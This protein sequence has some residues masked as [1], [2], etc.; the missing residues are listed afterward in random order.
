MDDRQAD[1]ETGGGSAYDDEHAEQTAEL[2]AQSDRLQHVHRMRHSDQ[3]DY[4]E[5]MDQQDYPS[6]QDADV[7]SYHQNQHQ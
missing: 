3:Q 1:E 7:N 6:G 2:G 4:D 5:E